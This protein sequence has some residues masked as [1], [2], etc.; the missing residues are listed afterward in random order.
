[1]SC[2][3]DFESV[4]TEGTCFS[5]FARADQEELA[6]RIAQGEFAAFTFQ[7]PSQPA[8]LWDVSLS[9]TYSGAV[10][11]DFG[12]DPTLLPAGF[13]ETEL[14]VYHFSG[15]TWAKLPGTVDP[16]AHSIAVSTPTLGVFALGAASLTNHTIA[17]TADP[18]NGGVITGAGSYVAGSS[19]TLTAAAS[20]GFFF[21]NWTENAAVVS[22]SPAFTFLAAADRTL[23]ANF[24]AAGSGK[25]ISTASTPTA[26]GTTSGDGEYEL[27]AR[28]TV[29]ATPNPGYKFSKWLVNGATVSS[30]KDYTFT[31]TGNLT[32]VAK[33]K[34]VYY[35][36]I[37][38]E[39]P[40]GGEPEGDPFYEMGELAK[41]KA[42][43][44]PGWSLVS[45]TQNGVVVS[46]DENFSFNVNGNRDLVA[47]YALGSRIDLLA[48]PK[49]AGKVSGAGVFDST[50]PVTVSAEPL[51]G[52]LFLEWTENGDPVSTAADYTFTTAKPRLLTARFIALP[53]ISMAPAAAPDQLTVSWPDA[54]GWVL[55]ESADLAG[56]AA[57]T[58]PIT[59]LNGQC[60]VTIF[61]SAGRV[62]FRLKYE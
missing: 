47:N 18:S 45:W 57:S 48:D 40:E 59:I 5:D 58:R 50:T 13:D 4:E 28:A 8:Q 55:Q 21:T 14:A 15:G 1:V 54:P 6:V 35:V 62:F 19:V 53:A 23:V 31:V 51:P 27:N 36:T 56:W 30:S 37:A 60:S 49:T 9:G 39:P 41:L 12:Y 25:V 34:P 43:P 42:K 17:A 2:D 11:V 3:Y 20:A 7:T 24:A 52:Y 33:F 44:L 46:T 16:L 10:Q 22:T 61:P 29:S 32:L 38:A 26:G